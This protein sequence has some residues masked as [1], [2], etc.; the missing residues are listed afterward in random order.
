MTNPTDRE[1]GASSRIYLRATSTGLADRV[2]AFRMSGG[3]SWPLNSDTITCMPLLTPDVVAAGTFSGTAQ[4][5]IAAGR[6][7]VLRPWNQRDAPAVFEA[8][9]G[10]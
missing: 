8:F 6:G 7:L 4:P 2:V 3:W 1:T 9:A 10:S 5:T